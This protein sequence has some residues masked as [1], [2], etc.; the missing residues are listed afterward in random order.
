MSSTMR[1]RKEGADVAWQAHAGRVPLGHCC[2][3]GLRNLRAPLRI[4][5]L[6]ECST[7]LR[8][9]G[10]VRRDK[11]VHTSLRFNGWLAVRR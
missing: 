2:A 4:D 11:S 8:S 9:V 5:R 7:P 1:Q 3:M 10:R 6:T